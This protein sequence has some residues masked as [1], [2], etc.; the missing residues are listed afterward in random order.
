MVE[1]NVGTI[2]SVKFMFMFLSTVI[3]LCVCVPL[4][5][6]VM[7]REAENFHLLCLRQKLDILALIKRK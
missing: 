2:S 6:G 4:C 7:Q 3:A 5:D 1:M